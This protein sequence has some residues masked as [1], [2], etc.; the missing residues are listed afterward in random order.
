[1]LCIKMV[2]VSDFGL[3]HSERV[4]PDGNLLPFPTGLALVRHNPWLRQCMW[5]VS[6]AGD[7]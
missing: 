6:E 3:G 1:M 5:D 2:I 4:P 7:I